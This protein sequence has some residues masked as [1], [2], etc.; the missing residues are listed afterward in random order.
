VS[1]FHAA[2]VKTPPEGDCSMAGASPW[3]ER[4]KPPSDADSRRPSARIVQA[5]RVTVRA[6]VFD[7]RTAIPR[8][9]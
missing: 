4:A 9:E 6:S 2:L 3:A 1:D 5:R 7:R 8:G